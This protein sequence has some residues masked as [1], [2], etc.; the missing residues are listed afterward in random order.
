MLLSTT[1]RRHA[2]ALLACLATVA[3]LGV[4][5]APAHALTL[6]F[7]DQDL[8]SSAGW[9]GGK[10]NLSDLNAG[11]AEAHTAGSQVWRFTVI[12]AEV[13]KSPV[14]P[15]PAEAVDPAWS[16]YDWSAVD[17]EVKAIT[18]NGM[19]PL[20]WASRAPTWA[21]GPNRPALSNEVPFGTWNPNPTLFGQFAQA[22]A[23]RYDGSYPDPA[24]PGQALP[25]ITY[26][27]GWN[28]PNL[29]T[30]LTPQWTK[31]N[32]KFV[33]TSPGIYR[34]LIN[35]FYAGVKQVQPTAVVLSAGT[36]PFGDLNPGD[37][38]I[39]P[40]AFY[41]ALLCET[42]KGTKV[43]VKKKCPR[44]NFDAWDHHT[45]PIGPPT[46]AAR[47]A[48]DVV[49]PDMAK[50]TRLVAAAAKAGVVK[51]AAV[52]NLWMTEMSW[53]SYPD[54]NGLSLADHALYMQGA[55]YIL[56]K[57]GVKNILWWN[58]RDDAQGSDWNAT[59]QSGIFLRGATPA[60]DTPKPSATAY[61]FPLAAYRYKGVAALWSRAPASGVVVVQAQ[62]AAGVWSTVVTL[63]SQGGQVFTGRLRVSPGTKLRAVQ[64]NQTSLTW[65]TF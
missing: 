64:G 45:Y 22:L 59:L 35:A 17:N 8:M 26:F 52:P 25:R 47:N 19:A 36:G 14:A 55:F 18:A 1:L 32:G 7:N 42:V 11:L 15:T 40:A 65:T 51:K 54:P 46:R 33:M 34:S 10:V 24:S 57:A 62:N 31:S 13:A 21:E 6:G 39:Q 27:Q 16:G 2:V 29:Y 12:W 48:D 60:Q 56:W 37:P 61:H 28:E 23:K 43:T 3:G 50:L 63:K 5:A 4:A 53:D 44:V 41:R 58:S 9:H 38:R 30:E 20:V 49:V